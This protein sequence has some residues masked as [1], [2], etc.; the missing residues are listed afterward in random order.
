[1]IRWS[2]IRRAAAIATVMT[3]AGVRPALAEEQFDVVVGKGEITVV[4]K[5]HWHVNKD[6]PWRV[7]VGDKM[8]DKSK[9]A[10]AETTAKVTG[11]PPGTVRLKGAVCEGN[12]CMP[13]TKEV[14]VE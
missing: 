3:G 1:M 5:G 7:M 9:F 10:L 14:A 13:F 4:A 8:I 11:V 2:A 6:Y 12:Q